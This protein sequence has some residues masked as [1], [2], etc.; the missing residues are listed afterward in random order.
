MNEH[1]KTEQAYK[2]GFKDGMTILA[3]LVKEYTKEKVT[4][5]TVDGF[6]E[7][8]KFIEKAIKVKVVMNGQEN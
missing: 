8:N 2:N 3:E 4:A 6:V 7:I 5:D 1:D